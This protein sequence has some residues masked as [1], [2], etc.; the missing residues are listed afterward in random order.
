MATIKQLQTLFSK[1]GIDVH[2]RKTRINAWT[3]GRTQSVKELQEEELKDLCESLSA[4]INLQKKHIDDAKR[5]RRST[6]LKIATAEGIKAPNDWDTF[7]DFMLH[8]SIVKKSLRLCSIEELD[9]VILQFRAIAQSNA[10]S[11][12][13]AGT[14][15][16]FKQFGLQK[17]CSN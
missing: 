1:L 9:R 13:K 5:L 3:S 16:Y 14:K 12:S 4:E 11:A 7:N 10:T 17:P 8:K 15:A 6:I 2:Q